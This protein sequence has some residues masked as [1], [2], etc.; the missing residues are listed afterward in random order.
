[1]SA[2]L[3]AGNTS[4]L[5]EMHIITSGL[6]VFVTT[7]TVRDIETARR[8]MGGHGFSAFSGLARLYAQYLPSATYEGD[9]F[10]LDHQVVRAALKAHNSVSSSPQPS[11]SPSARY[12]RLLNTTSVPFSGS[13]GDPS[14]LALLLEYRA[15]HVVHAHAQSVSS[16]LGDAG[17]SSRVA[18][19]ATGAFVAAQVVEM[20]NTLQTSGFRTNDQAVLKRLYTLYLLTEVESALSDL[21]AFGLLSVT[22]ANGDDP[23]QHLRDA[24]A[25]TCTALLPE[26]IGLSDAFGFTD[27]ELDSALGVHDG[28][29]Y[30]QLVERTKTEPMNQFDVS[31]AYE[32]SIRPILQRGQRRARALNGKA[33]L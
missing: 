30:E 5:A 1:M 29:V 17:A 24:I 11:F 12:L 7:H 3:A 4:L 27:W 23:A 10:V 28:R 16:G 21:Y 2:Q 9:N 14:A 26:A 20:V 22:S 31:P 13:W 8:S 18:Y 15:A 19:A 32:K 6:K 25:R 33:K